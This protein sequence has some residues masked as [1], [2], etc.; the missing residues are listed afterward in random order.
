MEW[1]LKLLAENARFYQTDFWF[2][3]LSLAL[4][5]IVGFGGKKVLVYVLFYGNKKKAEKYDHQMHGLQGFS[6][7][8]FW[9]AIVANAPFA[10]LTLGYTVWEWLSR[11]S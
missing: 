7:F 2:F 6:R 11:H 5:G 1:V 8:F 4:F 9:L 10:V 3:L